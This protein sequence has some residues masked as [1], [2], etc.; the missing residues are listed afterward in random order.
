MFSV[1]VCTFAFVSY[2]VLG[3]TAVDLGCEKVSRTPNVS[4]DQMPYVV[5]HSMLSTANFKVAVLAFLCNV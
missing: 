5:Y 4:N 1:Y 2:V 3:V